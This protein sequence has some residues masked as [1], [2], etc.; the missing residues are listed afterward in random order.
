[1]PSPG[2]VR[3]TLVSLGAKDSFSAGWSNV[4]AEVRR[5]RAGILI[6]IA[7]FILAGT[8]PARAQISPGA[9][10]KPHESLSGPTQC[11]SCHKVGFGSAVLKCQE[12]HVEIA[13]RI[14]QGRGFHARLVNKAD[15]A[16]CHS[17]HNGEDFPL[18]H[19]LPS[20]KAFDHNQAGYPLQGKHAGLE[21]NQCHKPENIREAGHGLIR[22]KDL[23][24]T[25]LGLSPGCVTCHVDV[26]KGQLGPNC[27]Q[28]HNFTN[29]KSATQFDH[30]KTRYPLTGLHGPVA[31]AKCHA[32]A[33]PKNEP[34]FRG[35]PFAKCSDC[36]SDPHHGRFPET[37]VTCHTT[38]GWRKIAGHDRFDHSKTKF[39]LLGG[40]AQVDC[41]RCHAGG[42]FNKPLAFANCSDCHTPNP[43]GGQFRARTDKGECS[44][45]HTVDA[46]KPSRFG[47]KEHAV[48]AYPLE[49][50]H[51]SVPC[52]K[53]HT[54]AGAAT[55]YKIAFARCTDCH[56]D[57]HQGQFAKPP[58]AG[59]CE[60]CHTIAAFQPSTFTIAQHQKSRYPLAGAHLAVTCSECH[61]AAKAQPPSRTAPYRFE[62]LTCTGCHTD[63]HKGQF[64]DRMAQLGSNGKPLGCE[65]CHTIQSW[66]NV[67]EFDHSK[68][69]FPL[70]GAHVKVACDGCHKPEREGGSISQVNFH[71]TPVQCSGCHVDVH[72]GQ[73]SHSGQPVDCALCHSSAQWKPS[74][75]N[76]ETGSTYSLK[77]AH[78]KVPCESC[79]D[80]YRVVAGKRVVFYKPTPRECS[81]CHN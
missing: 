20:L 56:T 48:T 3:A 11:A 73:F 7:V 28:C 12:C 55:R 32:P 67:K 74:L 6:C 21:C 26:H 45:C 60:A 52:A 33:G 66:T 27:A 65:A 77:G 71:S 16:K 79:H 75:F 51:A 17:E 54:P 39:P 35:I 62:D 24:R 61:A 13:Q 5:V 72:A 25:F 47:V 50:G 22:I 23:R 14:A 64:R 1:L 40:H 46:W 19:W 63:P 9:L 29:W 37:C 15:C 70:T 18:I 80:R 81:S 53:C 76:H 58:F 30:S 34:R 8:L 2:S 69:S 42:D 10:S 78:E 4:S 68:T 59:Q 44:A 38:S 57:V 36:H 43:H 49:G 31:C 41:V